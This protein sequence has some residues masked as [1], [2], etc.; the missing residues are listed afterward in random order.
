[1]DLFAAF[2]L[3]NRR[4]RPWIFGVI[5]GFHAVNAVVF[6][7]GIFPVMSISLTAL[8]FAPDFPSRIAEWLHKK[9][10]VDWKLPARYAA[11]TASWATAVSPLVLAVLVL[12]VMSIHIALPLR[13]HF[14][15]GDVTYTEEGH[16]YSWRMMLRS[17]RGSGRFVVKDPAS[18][19]EQRIDPYDYLWPRQ[20]NKMMT[21]PDMIWQFAQ[22]LESQFSEQYPGIEVYA[23]ISVKINDHP[24]EVFIDPDRNLAVEKW[25]FFRH[26]NWIT[27]QKYKA[28]WSRVF[29]N[30]DVNGTKSSKD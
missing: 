6:K 15:M 10:Q 14:F 7:I 12:A 11:C 17:K 30:S 22:H 3:I 18:G 8:F 26:H 21:H 13:H 4:T 5:I 9:W 2:L 27:E 20:R 29:H 25:Y 19:F 24:R 28:R 23:D 1:L 16:R